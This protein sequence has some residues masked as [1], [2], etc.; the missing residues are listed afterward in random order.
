VTPSQRARVANPAF[1]RAATYA[2]EFQFD[3]MMGPNVLWLAEWAS[4]AIDFQ[5]GMRVLDLGC[6][7][8]A[9]SI[10][11]AKEFG[12][13]VWAADLWVQ[14]TENWT[15]IEAA[16][17]AD[18]V[19]PLK[20]EAHA[21]PF[22]DRYFDVIV[23]FDAFHYFG[24]DDLYV[25]YV[26]RFLRP[27]GRL[28]A[29]S[30]GLVT[31]LKDGPPRHLLPF[32]DWRFASFHSPAWWNDHWAKTG[33]VQD[34]QADWLPDGWRHWADWSTL[35]AEVGA[36]RNPEGG[37]KEAQMLRLDAGRTLGFTRVAA[38]IR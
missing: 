15:R 9:S 2:A 20:T 10:F 4:R 5:P 29:V 34:L 25:G 16:G 13:T 14:P 26:S 7:K 37:A 23:S 36:G 30:P 24:T 17:L 22:A 31:E 3:T 6:G 28:C 12:P 35:C 21:L 32:W 38:R 18:R 33:L 27:G 1:P 19:L 11:I 8:A